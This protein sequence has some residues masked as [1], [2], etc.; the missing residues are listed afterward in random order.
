[1]CHLKKNIG[2]PAWNNGLSNPNAVNN[3]KRGADKLSKTVTGRKREYRE[4][5]TWF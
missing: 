5:G 4:D 3:G 1:M 2:K